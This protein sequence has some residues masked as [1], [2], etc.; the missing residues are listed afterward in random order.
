MDYHNTI[1]KLLK[2]NRVDGVFHSHVS[3]I[4]PMGK[5]IFNKQTQEEFWDLYCNYIREVENPIIGIAEKSQQYVQVIVDIDLKLKLNDDDTYHED[6]LY[7]EDQLKTIVGY[8]QSAL[9]TIVDGCTDEDLTCVVLEKKMYQQ[10]KNE[11][12][13]LKHGFHLQFPF[14]FLD[15]TLQEIHLIP[16]VQASLKES[17]MFR[18][19]GVEDSGTVVDKSCCK[20]PWLLY[21][22][23]KSETHE[24]YKV[25]KVL[26]S[27]LNEV[28]IKK[29]FEN[30]AVYDHKEQP[31]QVKG[32]VNKYLPRILSV[33]PNGRPTKELKKGIPSLLKEKMKKER[34]ASSVGTHSD[35]SPE[36]ALEEL[37]KIIPMLIDERASDFNDWMT[38][39]WVIHAETDGHPDGLELWC[40]FSERCGEKYDE[41]RCVYEWERMVK[42]GGGVTLGTLKYWAKRD[43]PVEYKK[44]VNDKVENKI[45]NKT[46]ESSHNDIAQALYEDYGD[47]FR[48]ASICNKAWFQFKNHVWEQIEEGVFLREKISGKLVKRYTDHIQTL[49][50]SLGNCGDDKGQQNMI[51]LKIK[52]IH[53]MIMNLKSAPY[54]NNVMKECLEVFYDPKFR[55]KLDTDPNLIAF[56]N[57]VFDLKNVVFRA[58][59]PDDYLSNNMPINYRVFSEDDEK[60]QEVHTFLEQVFPD[61]SVR[62]YFMDVSSDIFLGGNHEKIVC[63]WTGEGDNGKSI[64][65][66]FFDIM[67][68]RLSAKLNTNVITSKK[69][70][71]GSAFAD[72]AR[73][74]G[75]VRLCVLEEPDADELIN[76]G[77]FKHL[78]GGDNFFARDLFEKGKDTREIKPLFKINFVCNKL[79]GFRNPDKAVWNRVKVIPFESTFCK[80]DNP[81]PDSYEEQLRQKRFPMD[82]Q[83]GQKIP[84]LVEAFAWILLE[85]RK[86]VTVRIEPEKVV[87]ATEVYRK[88]NDIYRQFI[89][90]NIA[91]DSTKQISFAEIYNLFKEWFKNG[92]PGHTT[93]VK[94]DMEEYLRKLW[95]NPAVGMIWKGFRQRTINDDIENGDAVILTEKDLVDYGSGVAPL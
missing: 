80:A 8:Y 29:A 81:A 54:K 83:F 51:N 46:I 49:Y 62:K 50:S 15:K 3:L 68:G 69:P 67:L 61:K 57:G 24:P 78:S 5:F 95:G 21:G 76:S 38:V 4:N 14:L 47:E 36:E 41:N 60:V 20:V 94:V 26:D 72:L 18:Y 52:Q 71:A 84:G 27:D 65:Q 25:S 91:E 89:E 77:I 59:R 12:V 73:L 93:P 32:K 92:N 63:F 86:K 40:E 1:K 35:K 66:K 82:K 30:Y 33:V 16:R 7:S 9:R 2:N 22:S 17:D 64:T 31:I 45:F 85:H 88:R 87:A 79:P 11:S 70:G 90:E 39:G 28:S 10:T 56:K 74:G 75:G 37:R 53:K 13:Y 58:G 44:Y 43:N 34:K 19:L 55:E 6:C 48:C 23:R 42:K